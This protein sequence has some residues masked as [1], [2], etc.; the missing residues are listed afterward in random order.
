MKIT[1]AEAEP[2][3][4]LESAAGRVHTDSRW[5]KGVVRWKHQR[6]PV[7]AAFVRCI[8]RPREDVVPSVQVSQ[9][10]DIDSYS[11]HSRIFDSEG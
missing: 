9:A 5:R 10:I 3:R 4:G 8:G 6:T 1:N 2:S 11:T 7:L